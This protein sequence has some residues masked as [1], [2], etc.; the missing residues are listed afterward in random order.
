MKT[1]EPVIELLT[2]S[3]NLIYLRKDKIKI[4]K[5]KATEPNLLKYISLHLDTVWLL[6]ICQIDL[7]ISGVLLFIYCKTV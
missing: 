6:S 3:P 2:N 5:K 1:W 4:L 7:L